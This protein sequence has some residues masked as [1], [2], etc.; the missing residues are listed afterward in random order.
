MTIFEENKQH[1]VWYHLAIILVIAAIIILAPIVV[2]VF[3]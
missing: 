3:L 1:G 2:D